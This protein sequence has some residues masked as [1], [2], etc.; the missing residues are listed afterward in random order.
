VRCPEIVALADALADGPVL[1]GEILVWKEEPDPETGE[2]AGRPA[3]FALLQQRIGRKNL[4]RKVLA[5]AP[6]SFMAYDL[7]EQGG[8]DIR[9][10]PQRERR[11]RLEALLANGPFLISPVETADSWSEFARKRE[12]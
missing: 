8:E 2:V 12:R 1:D 10:L 9:S 11:A 3:A 4:T 6:V 5:E 7:L